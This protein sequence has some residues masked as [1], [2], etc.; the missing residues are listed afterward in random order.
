MKPALLLIAISLY[1]FPIKA[2]YKETFTDSRDGQIYETVCIGSQTWMT[3]N[4]NYDTDGSFAYLDDTSYTEKYGL[5]YT[6]ESAINVCPSGWHLPTDNEWKQLESII[7]MSESEVDNSFWRGTT[8]GTTLKASVGWSMN[9][10]TDSYGFSMLP[11]GYRSINGKYDLAG[12]Y[13]YCWTAT[14]L[15]CDVAWYRRFC[16]SREQILRFTNNKRQGYS[17]RCI[18]DLL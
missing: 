8:E 2:Q 11:G 12:E 3:Q 18:K 1:C 14:V 10:G 6:W 15:T 9:N 17:I 4:L 13:G 7:G 16:G 5:L